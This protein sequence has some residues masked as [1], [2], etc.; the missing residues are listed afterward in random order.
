MTLNGTS[1]ALGI[2]IAS[3]GSLLQVN[4]NAAIGYPANTAGPSM[5][6]AVSGSV[7]IN[8]DSPSL[9]GTMLDV[10]GDFAMRENSPAQITANQNDYAIGSYSVL[11]LTSDGSYNITG[12]AGGVQG[13]FL[14]II[15][16]NLY[17]SGRNLTLKHDQTSSTANRIYTPNQL[18]F[19]L[20][21]A[22]VAIL[23]YDSTSA[24]WRVLK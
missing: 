13:K 16:V 6:L 10:K 21:P 3:P 23:W 9:P 22:G 11:R 14:Y 12:F 8:L 1:G 5:G 24:R 15:N 4:G 20:A 17:G 2:G 18:D 7:G 19:T